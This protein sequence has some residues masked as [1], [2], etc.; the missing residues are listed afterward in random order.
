MRDL[1]DTITDRGTDTTA[2]SLEQVTF[3]TAA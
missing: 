3:N 2:T 1:Q